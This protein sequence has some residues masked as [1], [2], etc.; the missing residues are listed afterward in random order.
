ML[1]STP[2]TQSK[3]AREKD[4]IGNDF[5]FFDKINAQCHPQPVFKMDTHPVDVLVAEDEPLNML[6]ISEV[7]KN[8]GCNVIK[9]CNGEEA[10]AILKH[11]KPA[12]IFMD[13]NM[14]EMD[15]YEATRT[16]RQ[17]PGSQKNTP[18]IALTADVM[19][20]DQDR[21]LQAGMNHYIS[22]PFARKRIEEILK[23]YVSA[24]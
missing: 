19:K 16:I 15:G 20:E 12:L 13:L 17:L 24:A 3:T 8:M 2:S 6:L 7:L 23:Y 14:P 22:K 21:C 18:I 4:A 1:L 11:R 9:A 10:V 5:F